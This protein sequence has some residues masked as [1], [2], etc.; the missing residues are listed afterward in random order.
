MESFALGAV[1]RPLT[2]EDLKMIQYQS[3]KTD[4]IFITSDGTSPYNSM[5]KWAVKRYYRKDNN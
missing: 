3:Q 5:R 2:R 4:A 1:K